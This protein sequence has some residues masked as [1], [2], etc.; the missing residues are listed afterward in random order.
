MKKMKRE[1]VAADHRVINEADFRAG[2]V[3]S[4]V[5]NNKYFSTS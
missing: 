1:G 5:E 2:K 4:P 3:S